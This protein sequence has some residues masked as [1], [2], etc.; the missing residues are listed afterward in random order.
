MVLKDKDLFMQDTDNT[1]ISTEDI[2]LAEGT[3]GQEVVENPETITTEQVVEDPTKEVKE[4]TTE[5]KTTE[6]VVAEEPKKE[7]TKAEDDKSLS[8]I[9]E[10]LDKIQIEG[11]KKEEA[12]DAAVEEAKKAVEDDVEKTKM[13]ELLSNLDKELVAERSEKKKLMYT[14]DFL[15][16]QID[17]LT[18]ENIWYK[19]W[20]ADEDWLL[21]LINNDSWMKSIISQELKAQSWNP[22]DKEALVGAYKT[23]LEE[24][25]GLKFDDFIAAS[26]KW[27]EGQMW[28]AEEDVSMS[29]ETQDWESMFL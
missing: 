21:Q 9:L 16:S 4:V 1:S 11:E 18:K 20:R 3:Q 14:V 6:E 23:K 12:T 7:E 24:L 15:Q 27:A 29:V 13:T 17:T 19:Y 22:A 26:K 8:Q 25:T 2:A 10:E 5:E 28:E